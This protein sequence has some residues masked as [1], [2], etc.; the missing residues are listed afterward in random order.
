MGIA[1]EGNDEATVTLALALSALREC[2]DPAAV[3][4]DAREWSRHVVIVDRYPA[5]VKEFAED[6]DIPSTETFDGDK[7]E[8]MEAVGASTHTPRR[9]FVGVTDGDQTIAMHLD[10]E[11]RPIE[12][13][14]EKAHWT[15]KRHSQSQS[16]FRDRLERLW[17]F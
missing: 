6:H 3:V 12:E 7:W 15:L 14:A 17:P 5:A 13:A 2:E 11:Y 1:V 4:A 9:V 10:W 16:G 8:T